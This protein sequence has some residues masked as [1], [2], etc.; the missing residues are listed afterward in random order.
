MRSNVTEQGIM[1]V[2]AFVDVAM[3]FRVCVIHQCRDTFTWTFILF[4]LSVASFTMEVLP[5]HW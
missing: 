4:L 5:A 2:H 3:V 1:F